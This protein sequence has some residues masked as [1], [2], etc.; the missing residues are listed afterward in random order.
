MCF[1]LFKSSTLYMHQPSGFPYVGRHRQSSGDCPR[2]DPS[3]TPLTHMHIRLHPRIPSLCHYGM[4]RVDPIASCHQHSWS[5]HCITVSV[6]KC[7]ERKQMARC[8]V[9]TQ[10]E[11]E[12]KGCALYLE[13]GDKERVIQ[14]RRSNPVYKECDRHETADKSGPA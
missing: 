1:V 6:R 13:K 4:M 14:S 7:G 10:R 11:A 2:R 12:G 3:T 9:R 5:L 8:R